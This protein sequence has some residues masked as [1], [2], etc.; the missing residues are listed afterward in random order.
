MTTRLDTTETKVAFD[1][2]RGQIKKLE[3]SIMAV[4]KNGSG[5]LG[6]PEDIEKIVTSAVESLQVARSEIE[7]L[8]CWYDS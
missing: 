2:V 5:P 3:G 7:R 1:Q 4:Y 8:I 6:T